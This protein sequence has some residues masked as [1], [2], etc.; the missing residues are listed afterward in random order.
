MQP[1]QSSTLGAVT[2]SLKISL[3]IFVIVWA[4]GHPVCCLPPSARPLPS[5][6]FPRNMPFSAL[7]LAGVR[8]LCTRM[9]GLVYVPPFVCMWWLS[10]EQE[11]QQA[12]RPQSACSPGSRRHACHVYLL[13]AGSLYPAKCWLATLARGQ[14]M[15]ETTSCRSCPAWPQVSLA[16][17]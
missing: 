1:G 6:L 13:T 9:R 5:A 3:P 4:A 7:S 14:G 8:T 2:A 10:G 15:V 12:V 16:T 17:C 11:R